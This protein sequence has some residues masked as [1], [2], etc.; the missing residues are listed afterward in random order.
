[1]EEC[2][3]LR[4]EHEQS[5]SRDVVGVGVVQDR[6]SQG[7]LKGPVG[8]SHSDML[9]T[10]VCLRYGTLRTNSGRVPRILG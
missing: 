2:P 9:G 5:R 3:R 4:E 10:H 6:G 1:M 8:T 7:G